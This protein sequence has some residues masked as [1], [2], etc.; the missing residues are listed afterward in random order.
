MAGRVDGGGRRMW[1]GCTGQM[2]GAEPRKGQEEG[3]APSSGEVGLRETLGFR[4]A[5]SREGGG[6][7]GHCAV[8]QAHS[9]PDLPCSLWEEECCSP[10]EPREWSGSF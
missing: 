8:T 4:L 1:G 9:C 7:T 10:S 2:Q 3:T 5:R 6:A